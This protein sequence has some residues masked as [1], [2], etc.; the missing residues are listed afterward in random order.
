[1]HSYLIPLV[2]ENAILEQFQLDKTDG[3]RNSRNVRLRAEDT[4]EATEGGRRRRR[5]APALPAGLPEPMAAST[6]I[7][8]EESREPSDPRLCCGPTSTT[9]AAAA[10]QTVAD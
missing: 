9:E 10:A 8:L 1:M 4:R 3:Y 6:L 7:A 5:A 2:L